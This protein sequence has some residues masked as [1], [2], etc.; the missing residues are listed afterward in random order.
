MKTFYDCILAELES[1][2]GELMRLYELR[3][4]L[5]YVEAPPLRERYMEAIGVYEEPV[6]EAELEVS[7]LRRKLQLIQ[8]A[9]NRREPVDMEAIDAAIEKEKEKRLSDL[10]SAD[11]T[12]DEL[13][14]L[15]GDE[16]KYLQELY[17][18]VVDTFHPE[19]NEIM[20]YVVV[21][22]QYQT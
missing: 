7:L 4:W 11:M 15:S 6:L 13:P 5:L 1:V 16:Q 3:D 8:A 14:S 17:G 10:E 20:Y 12:L 18:L 21:F 22:N 2:R 19:L 9:V